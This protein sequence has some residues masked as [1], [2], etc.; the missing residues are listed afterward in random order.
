MYTG[1]EERVVGREDAD[2]GMTGDTGR[3]V[4]DPGNTGDAYKGLQ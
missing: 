4:E 3:Q 1:R 2:E